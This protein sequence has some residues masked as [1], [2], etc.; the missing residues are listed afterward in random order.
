MNTPIPQKSKFESSP[1]L[2]CQ[3][4]FVLGIMSLCVSVTEVGKSDV[5]KTVGVS[6]GPCV[7]PVVCSTG[8]TPL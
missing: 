7:A 2:G 4:S 3:V 1:T 8:S 6:L 5:W